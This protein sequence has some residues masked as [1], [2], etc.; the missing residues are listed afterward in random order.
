MIEEQEDTLQLL[1]KSREC[2]E[3]AYSRLTVGFSYG[4]VVEGEL[5]LDEPAE[6][7]DQEESEAIQKLGYT[8]SDINE[9]IENLEEREV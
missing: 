5:E 8:I 4:T 1:Y 6:A 2:L 7:E 9:L 3:I